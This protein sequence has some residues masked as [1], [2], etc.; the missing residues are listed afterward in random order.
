MK[1]KRWIGIVFLFF[2]F[3]GCDKEPQS[4]VWEGDIP[5]YYLDTAET[6]I[7]REG[8]TPLSAE[9]EPM[10][11]E[12]L[13]HMQSP[14]SEEHVAAVPETVNLPE[15]SMSAS[16]L[17]TLQFDET[18][19]MVSGVREVLM[20]AAVVKT[21]CQVPEI[22]SVEFYVT[23]QPLMG[24]QNTP[25]GIMKSEDFIDNTGPETDYYQYLY[26]TVYYANRTGDALIASN[27]KIPYSGS[28]TEEQI[29]LRQLIAGPVEDELYPVL[30]EKTEVLSTSTKD[31]VCYV[32][33]SEEFLDKLPEVTEEITIYSVVNSLAELPGIYRVQFSINGAQKKLYQT[34]DLTLPYERNLN[35]IEKE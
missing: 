2:L 29:V 32:D 31:G 16:G 3:A 7:V 5:V 9:G 24:T 21:V 8:Y 26:T 34:M 19:Y 12:L 22:D 13:T 25:I 23:G 4:T 10:V 18:Y 6:K 14:L 11:K 33:F 20:R 30:S 28:E 1:Q 17:V 15:V 27:L 35:V